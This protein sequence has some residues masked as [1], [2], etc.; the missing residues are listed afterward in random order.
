MINE[1]RARAALLL[2][3][4]EFSRVHSGGLQNLHIAAD[5]IRAAADEIVR[6]RAEV[7]VLKGSGAKLY[8]IAASG[9]DPAARRRMIDRM[10]E[11]SF[12][13]HG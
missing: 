6:L 3:G 2:Q 9:A 8:D 10:G 1:L 7:A 12:A 4:P 13:E 11:E 5:Q